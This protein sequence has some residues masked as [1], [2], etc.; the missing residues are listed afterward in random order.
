M[1][2]HEIPEPLDLSGRWRAGVADEELRRVWYADDFDDASFVD[3]DVPGHWRRNE[4]FADNDDPLLYRRHFS[5]LTPGADTR[6]WLELDGVCSQGDVWLDGEYLGNTDG[7]WVPHRFEVTR[8]LGERNEH[9]LA[10][11]VTSRQPGDR[12]AKHGLLGTWQDGP[13]VEP[14]WNPGGIW[15]PVTLRRTGPVAV[16]SHRVLCTAATQDRATVTVRCVLDAAAAGEVTVRTLVGDIDDEHLHTLARGENLLTWSVEVANP[17][18][19]W[20]AELGGQPLVDVTVEIT[21]ARAVDGTGP[22]NPSDRFTARCGLRQVT[23]DNWIFTINGERLF[24]RGVLA[25]PAAHELGTAPDDVF[26]AQITAAAATGCNLVRVHGHLSAPALYDAADAAGMLIWQDLPLYRGQHRSV[27]RTAIRT[28]AAAVD[29]LGAH[30]SLVLWCGH[31]EPDDA[32]I[33]GDGR[34]GLLRRFGAHELPNWNRSVLDPSVKRSLVAADPSR[35]VIGSSGTWPR[36]P[37]LTGTDTHLELGWS[38]GEPTDLA[39]IA[40][41]IPRAV[42]FVQ[43]TPPPSWALDPTAHAAAT[44]PRTDLVGSTSGSAVD[45]ALLAERYPPEAY[46][47]PAAFHDALRRGQADA[48]RIQVELLRRLKYRPTGGFVVGYLHDLRDVP[49][50]ALISADG[51]D[52]PA[53]AALRAACAPVLV[54]LSPWPTHPQPG[55]PVE[56]AVHIVND[57]HRALVDA[58]LSVEI[59]AGSSE[60]RWTFV[61]GVEADG[62]ARVGQ[63][64]FTVPRAAGRLDASFRLAA[65]TTSVAGHYTS[66]VRTDRPGDDGTV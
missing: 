1:T 2:D 31:D 32:H 15:R 40:R 57:R 12:A 17:D 51:V 65:G 4:A 47:S 28:A 46:P 62:V 38:E 49:S 50:P 56:C 16:R 6:A 14:G 10:V 58:T 35:P 60:R 33:H 61:G 44:W 18:L 13:Y 54:T 5:T 52:K 63:V 66:V 37:A 22:T 41:T 30:P 26:T 11:E 39:R 29:R 43:I 8:A 64:T 20:P 53:R 34:V 7:A 42:R 45:P 21:P 19:W 59:T 55:A 23:L 3:V 27:R 24:L 48:I 25:P 9:T 36:P